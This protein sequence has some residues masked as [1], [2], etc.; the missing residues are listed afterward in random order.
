M[1]VD[2]ARDARFFGLVW[3]LVGKWL[4]WPWTDRWIVI[5]AMVLLPIVALGVRL[6][7]YQRVRHWMG[8]T[9]TQSENAGA[10][11][12]LTQSEVEQ[13]TKIGWLVNVAA[14]RGIYRANCLTRS[15]TL[16]WLLARRGI[17]SDIVFG[18]RIA[19]TELRAHAWVQCRDTVIND[20]QGVAERFR[21]F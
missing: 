21:A 20:H 6:A 11:N 4:R 12:E 17:V 7:G 1:S 3:H 19:K 14:R 5:Q 15:L 10:R 18:T 13:A 16:W 2:L 9:L 8:W